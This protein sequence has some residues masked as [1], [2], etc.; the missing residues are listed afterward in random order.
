MKHIIKNGTQ[1]MKET[2]LQTL[3]QMKSIRKVCVFLDNNN[4]LI[5]D[6]QPKTP[7]T[8]LILQDDAGN[9]IHI[10]FGNCGYHGKGPDNTVWVLEM[11][12]VDIETARQLVYHND[13]LQ[14]SLS[15]NGQ[16]Q[17]RSI[18]TRV[19]FCPFQ[20]LSDT[21]G[22]IENHVAAEVYLTQ[23]KVILFNP[24]YN[25]FSGLLRAID[26]MKINEMEYYIG[27]NSP[28]ENFFRFNIDYKSRG[29]P[30]PKESKGCNMSGLS[31]V[32]LS[33]RGQRFDISCLVSRDIEVPFINTIY[34]YLTGDTLFSND[35][36][37]QY[38]KYKTSWL[39]RKKNFDLHKTIKLIDK[40]DRKYNEHI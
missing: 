14:F 16:I 38:Y 36:M 5:T 13:G 20:R 29:L 11:L 1:N 6:F 17:P 30:L 35:I 25:C 33:L 24:Q 32:N 12:G 2:F 27:K 28:L 8:N 3:S 7:D 15:A 31:H 39:M 23:R 37:T 34:T 4:F 21:F 18:N 9:E 10:E 22:I 26:D 40:K 19:L